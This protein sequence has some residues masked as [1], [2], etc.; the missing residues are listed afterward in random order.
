MPAPAAPYGYGPPAGY[1]AAPRQYP[2]YHEQACL[3]VRTVGVVS[4]SGECFV[5]AKRKQ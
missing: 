4:R 3:F 1:R 2:E 5:N